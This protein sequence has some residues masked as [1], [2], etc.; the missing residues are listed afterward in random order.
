MLLIPVG[1]ERLRSRLLLARVS[2]RSY[3]GFSKYKNTLHRYL[4][5]TSSLF[6]DHY[7]LRPLTKEHDR[8]SGILHL[9]CELGTRFQLQVKLEII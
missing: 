2:L 9:F 8:K 1:L 4:P 6:S 5:N 7:Q 3:T